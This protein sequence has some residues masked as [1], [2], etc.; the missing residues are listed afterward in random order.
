M[1]KWPDSPTQAAPTNELADFVELICWRDHLAS[2]T[3]ISR[4]LG[5]L[6]EG[7]SSDGI[8]EEDTD[9]A[10]DEAFVEIERRIEACGEGYPFIFGQEGS[11]LQATE[12]IGNPQHE[13]YK[14]LL[15]ATRL[16]MNVHKNHVNIDGTQIFE[17]LSAEV[18]KGYFGDRTKSL[19][20]GTA[21]GSVD[22]PSK[23]DD[24]CDQLNEGGGY[25]N[26]GGSVRPRD[27]KLDV[28][29]W[30]PFAD[31]LPGK[32]IGF[33]QC[34]TGTYY[35]GELTQLQPDTFRDMWIRSP[36][37][38]PPMRMFFIAEALSSYPEDRL[39]ISRQAGI[40]FDRCRIIDF[41]DVVDADV[42]AK[43]RQWTAFAATSVDLAG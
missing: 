43:V 42:L 39:Y 21:A 27:G 7:E 13:V 41:C 32:L 5:R 25:I 14:Y 37:I 4:L 35:E 28:V 1:F 31:D 33:G 16:R 30:K 10:V 8:P 29:A 12:E 36:I 11:T 26:N 19:V 23:V 34:K 40:L 17:E 9:Q 20:F 2:A 24:L 22:F 6:G 38:V 3:A 15:L 18:A